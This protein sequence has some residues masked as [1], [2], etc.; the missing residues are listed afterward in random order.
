[1]GQKTRHEQ[2]IVPK[3]SP[4]KGLGTKRFDIK[5]GQ[6]AVWAKSGVGQKW[7]G[8][9]VVRKTKKHGKTNQKI[10]LTPKKMKKNRK[11]PRIKK[12]EKYLSSPLPDQRIKKNQQQNQKI[13][14]MLKERESKQNIAQTRKFQKKKKSKKSENLLLFLILFLFSSLF[15]F[16]FVIW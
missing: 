12:M 11:M 14:K 13:Q 10:S 7:C 8:P 3:S 4:S 9:K 1:M 2:Q 16:F 6:E 5:K 15:M